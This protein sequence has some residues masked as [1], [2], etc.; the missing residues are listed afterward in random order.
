MNYYIDMTQKQDIF[1]VMNGR[2]KFK[3]GKYNLT[4]DAVW[5]AAAAQPVKTILDAG[6]GTGGVSLCIL[7]HNPDATI[8]GID[9]SDEMLSAC[10][11]NAKIN[12]R[13]IELINTDITKW[14]TDR[15]FDLVIT[16]PPYFT[17]SPAKHNAHH[18]TDLTI[19]TEKCLSRIHPGGYFCTII[20][21]AVLSK[22]IAAIEK[23]CG[24]ITII[25]LFSSKNT[26]ERVIITAKLGSKGK[27]TLNTGFPMNYDKILRDGLTINRI[28]TT[29]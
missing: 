22:M 10:T 12:N 16:N 7:E 20:D 15:T 1:T 29:I 21:A 26:A 24:N 2:V 19:W 4:S 13:E 3:R 25:P 18:N 9:I 6:I 5:L 28:L 11:E 23:K 8:T 14:K 27:T 17:G